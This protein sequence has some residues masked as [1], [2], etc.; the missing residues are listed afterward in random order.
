MTTRE[1]IEYYGYV[2]GRHVRRTLSPNEVPAGKRYVRAYNQIYRATLERSPSR[3]ARSYLPWFMPSQWRQSMPFAWQS[4][5]GAERGEFTD[6]TYITS[7]NSPLLDITSRRALS[8]VEPTRAQRRMV[9]AEYSAYVAKAVRM[10][11]DDVDEDDLD[12]ESRI[13]RLTIQRMDAD[14]VARRFGVITRANVMEWYDTQANETEPLVVRPKTKADEDNGACLFL[15]NTYWRDELDVDEVK[16]RDSQVVEDARVEGQAEAFTWRAHLIR[17]HGLEPKPEHV[18]FEG[19]MPR[20]GWHMA[21]RFAM[22]ECL[23]TCEGG[24]SSHV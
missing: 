9:W 20:T 6:P 11:L 4:S 17:D 12:L 16:T 19:D 13:T 23:A 1:D 8:M 14:E 3:E 7:S 22:D 18:A 21:K 5:E 15:A 10:V 24:W 2:V